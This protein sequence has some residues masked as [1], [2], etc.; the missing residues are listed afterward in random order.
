MIVQRSYYVNYQGKKVFI[1][2]KTEKFVNTFFVYFSDR[3][4]DEDLVYTYYDQPVDYTSDSLFFNIAVQ[5][6]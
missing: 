2:E 6:H 4:W 1:L 3:S 5:V